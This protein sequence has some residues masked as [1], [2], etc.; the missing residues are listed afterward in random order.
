MVSAVVLALVGPVGSA[1]ATKSFSTKPVPAVSGTLRVGSTVT[2]NPR[3]WAPRPT[4]LSY[5]W[6]VGS[7]AVK[8][9]TG[10]SWKLPAAVSGKRIHVT[11]TA[12]RAGYA[13][14]SRASAAKKVTP[15]VLAGP[16]PT[17]SG[18]A[19]VGSTLT[20]VPGTWSP[21]TTLRYQWSR[22]GAAVSG[23][24]GPTYAVGFA[25]EGAAISVTVTGAKA[26]HAARSVTSAAVTVA[27]PSALGAGQTLL[28]GQYLRSPSGQYTLVQQDDGNLVEYKDSTA[29][30][31]SGTHGSG[32]RTAMQG[33][34]NAVVYD[35]G[36]AKWSTDS[37]GSGGTQ[38][39]LQDDGN[40]VVYDANGKAVWAPNVVG[41][42]TVY[43][44][45]TAG[46]AS[47]TQ[48]Q[49]QA[50]LASTQFRVYPVG[51]R[52]PVTCGI[53][54]GQAVD[55]SAT[56]GTAKTSTWHRLLWGDWVADADF[57]TTVDGLVPKGI[58]GFVANEPNC[59]GGGGGGQT[60]T[61]PGMNGW[62][63]PIQPHA[64]LTTYSGHNGDDFPVGIGT[65]V[66]AMY[67]G[68]VSIPAAYAVTSAWCPV[69]AAIGRTQ[70]DLIVNSSRDGHAYRFDYAHLSSF[71]V[72]NG[73]TVQAGTL[74]GYSGD[75]GCVTGPHLHIDIKLDGKANQIYPHNLI[76]WSY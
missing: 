28:A 76:G 13:T 6:Y 4:S 55:G 45:S 69:A 46:G 50:T 31:S 19:T 64:K 36:S 70:Q 73:Q 37:W 2:A 72:S 58:L 21:R 51:T 41:W 32:L 52:L 1:S 38:L 34:G 11:V 22:S 62:V 60:T 65:P 42:I 33:D 29:V 23:A 15:G 27:V 14:A 8:G 12:R 26:G 39:V 5:Q 17:I 16:S 30:W 68:T 43:T 67:G 66:Y 54:N 61:L 44:G 10:R 49:S 47:G 74:L 48:S 71:S 20:A 56:P 7:H 18:P 35:G 63:Y 24:T 75:R 25:D 40:L 57:K 59:G 3:K 9:A 53:T